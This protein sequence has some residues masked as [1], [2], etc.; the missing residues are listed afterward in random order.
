MKLLR[1]NKQLDVPVLCV[2]QQ[3]IQHLVQVAGIDGVTIWHV[4]PKAYYLSAK[5]KNKSEN[6]FLSTRRDPHS[7][8]TFKRVE[9]AVRVGRTLFNTLEFK[10]IVKPPQSLRASR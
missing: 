6:C 7:P 10:L 8:R 1:V 9:I 5:V 4:G 2:Q 3:F